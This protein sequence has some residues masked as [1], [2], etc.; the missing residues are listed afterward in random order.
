MNNSFFISEYFID[1]IPKGKSCKMQQAWDQPYLIMEVLT[2]PTIQIDITHAKL[3]ESLTIYF[4]PFLETVR[5][6]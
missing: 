6:L 5:F 2:S 1:S 3:Q 4:V